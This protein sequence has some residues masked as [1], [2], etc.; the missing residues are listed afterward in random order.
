[1]IDEKEIPYPPP[2]LPNVDY[3][4]FDESFEPL[5]DL[6]HGALEHCQHFLKKLESVLL[7][8]KMVQIPELIVAHL[9]CYLGAS[10]TVC[11]AEKAKPLEPNIIGLIKQHADCAFAQFNRYPINSSVSTQRE[12]QNNLAKLREQCPGSIIAQTVR[13]GRFV[14]DIMERL[15]SN[16]RLTLKYSDQKQEE[17]FCPQNE[18]FAFLIPLINEQHH[19]WQETLDG[20]SINYAVNQLAIQIAWLIGYF[21]HLDHQ[22]PDAGRYLEYGLPCIALYREHTDEF[23]QA[24][25]AKGQAVTSMQTDSVDEPSVDPEI[26]AL[27]HEIHTL[28]S[29]THANL[30]PAITTFQKEIAIVQAG[31]EKLLIELMAEGMAVKVVLMSVFYFWFTLDAPLR[32]EDPTVFDN[33]SPFDEMGNIIDLVKST[34]RSLPE[35]KLSSELK[36]LNAKMQA[37]K[38]NLP[39]PASLDEVDQATVAYQSKKVNTAIHTLTSNY[40]KQNYHVEVVANVLFSQWMHLSVFYGVSESDWQKMDYYLVEI[41]AAVRNYIPTTIIKN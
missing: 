41:L 36:L 9:C 12:K 11:L 31:I 16:R 20:K 38:T 25:R 2:M 22:A 3:Q 19:E 1:M 7:D 6:E 10:T 21:S 13:L 14:M 39:D 27:L 28:S 35:P 37:L 32:V 8:A 30:P 34:V 26:E 15:G 4:T 29:K 24:M 18:F 33:Y 5:V 40:L 17:F 23:L